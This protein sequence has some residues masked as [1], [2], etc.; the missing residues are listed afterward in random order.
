VSALSQQVRKL[1][2]LR[3]SLSCDRGK[4]MSDH[5]PFTIATDVQVYFCV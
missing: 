3:R 5:K 4:E 2:Q 1:P